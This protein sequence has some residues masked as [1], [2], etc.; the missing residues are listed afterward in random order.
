MKP[1][2]LINIRGRLLDL[3]REPIVMGILNHTPD[4]FFSGSRIQGDRAIHDRIEQILREGG[5]MVDVGG[6]STRPD[7]TEVSPEEE[8]ARVAQVLEILKRDYPEVIVSVDTFR[9]DVARKAVEIGGA[10]LI[11]DVSGGL[12]DSEMYATVGSLQVPY[13]LMH[14]RG[15]PKTMQSLTEYSG[16]VTDVVISELLRP[17]EKARAAGIKDIILDPGFGFSKTLDQNYELMSELDKFAT[18]GLPLLVGISRKSMIYRLFE[19]SP[20]E[21]LNGTSILNTFALLHGAHILRVHDV[22]EAVEAVKIV[23]KLKPSA[24]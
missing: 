24:E 12:L 20:Q 13:I 21:A 19:T 3:G 5:S 10:D 15:T 14:M 7:A 2:L 22:K 23:A 1:S 6:Y 4:S 9:A 16:K 17:I 8:W 11:N 18:L